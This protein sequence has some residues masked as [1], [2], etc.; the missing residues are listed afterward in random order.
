MAIT[1]EFRLSWEQDPLVSIARKVPECTITVE[2]DELTVTG[3]IV[4]LL[5]VVCGSFE[6]F[7]AALE[8]EPDITEFTLIS[9]EDS[10]RTYHTVFEWSSYP[11]EMDELLFNKTLVER[12]WITSDGEYFKQQF[13][14]RDELVAYRESCQNMGI[15]FRLKRLY[16]SNDD[17]RIPGMSEKQRKA[18]LAA[19]EAGYF[20]VPR[21][22]SLR[23]V[24]D[25]LD[26]SR[27]AF[28]ER[29]HRGLS[30]VLEHYVSDRL[31]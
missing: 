22:A 2:Y 11:E 14:D 20:D 13:A 27:S 5:R 4:L 9:D 23:E 10:G 24:A 30:H 31:Y 18:L 8:D 6:A 19:Y 12:W 3:P 26:I 7:E 25:S 29:L 15:N 28:T 16:E 17:Q 1:A 21:Q